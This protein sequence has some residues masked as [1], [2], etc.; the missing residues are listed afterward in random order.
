MGVIINHK[1]HYSTRLP[2]W[3]IGIVFVGLSPIIIGLLGAWI[4]EITT[5]QACHE[6][7]CMWMTLPWLAMLSIPIG[8]IGL[9]IFSIIILIDSISL[10]K[11][12]NDTTKRSKPH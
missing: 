9:I 11:R 1:K 4:T 2:L 7:N 5:G 6:G 12:K 8:G 10:I 3:L